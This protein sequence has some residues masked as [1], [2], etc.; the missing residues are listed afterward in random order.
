MASMLQCFN[1]NNECHSVA[2]VLQCL[3]HNNECHSMASM[4]QGGVSVVR[5]VGTGEGQGQLCPG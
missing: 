1:H 2:S 3:N 5:L 4:L